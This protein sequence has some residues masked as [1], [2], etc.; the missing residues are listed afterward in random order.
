MALRRPSLGVM[1]GAF[2]TSAA[3]NGL[4]DNNPRELEHVGSG[5]G[6]QAGAEAGEIDTTTTGAS[7]S[8][9][10]GTGTSAG[11]GAGAAG[12]V[13]ASGTAGAAGQAGAAGA[14][15][16]DTGPTSDSSTSTQTTAT[17]T[18][19]GGTTNV[20]EGTPSECLP[21]DSED[22]PRPCACN[23]GTQTRPKTCSEGCVWTY[24]EWSACSVTPECESGSQ[25]QVVNCPCG[26]TK[27][28]TR[29]C[30]DACIWSTWTDVTACADLNCCTEL[31]YCNTPDDIGVP[32][33]W[34]TW[35]R[36]K[37]EGS[38]CTA[39]EVVADCMADLGRYDCTLQQ[40][41]Y[42]EYL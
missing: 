6:G 8:T 5:G 29:S 21:G 39:D 10:T 4:L 35:C 26:G 3:C 19:A 40:E 7:T 17:A 25:D 13:G 28:R 22:E 18:S 34:G 36:Q 11:A 16:A 33:S 31:V 9:G 2:I 42:I 23:L 27:T 14:P 24:G 15:A 32:A 30:T 37:S 1:L 41:L 20:C 12:G 38:A